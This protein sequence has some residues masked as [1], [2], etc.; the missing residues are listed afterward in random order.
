MRVGEYCFVVKQ[1]CNEM[2]KHGQGLLEGFQMIVNIEK[3]HRK[4]SLSPLSLS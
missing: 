4:I 1:I 2:M 3:L